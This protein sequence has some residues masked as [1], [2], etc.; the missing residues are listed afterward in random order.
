MDSVLGITTAIVPEYLSTPAI[1]RYPGIAF[2]TQ[3]RDAKGRP[4]D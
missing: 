4:E 1:N 2:W 3:K